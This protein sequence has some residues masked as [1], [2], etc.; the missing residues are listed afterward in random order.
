MARDR[1]EPLFPLV[2]GIAS[3]GIASLF[4]ILASCETLPEADSGG[5]EISGLEHRTEKGE[6][7]NATLL[8]L[9]ETERMQ[10]LNRLQRIYRNEEGVRVTHGVVIHATQKNGNRYSGDLLVHFEKGT[11]LTGPGHATGGA[12]TVAGASLVIQEFRLL[13]A[14]GGDQ[15]LPLSDE[16]RLV[17]DWDNDSLKTSSESGRFRLRQSISD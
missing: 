1:K 5:D 17:I 8:H 3:V 10:D 6:E 15:I 14:T 16:A 11:P 9:L 4:A 2:S 13:N 7:E 12:A